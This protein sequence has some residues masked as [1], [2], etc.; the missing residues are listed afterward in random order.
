LVVTS[1]NGGGLFYGRIGSNGSGSVNAS[2]IF[3]PASTTAYLDPRLAWSSG[4]GQWGVAYSTNGI[5]GL[6]AYAGVMSSTSA[7]WQSVAVSGSRVDV[8]ARGQGDLLFLTSSLN[9]LNLVTQGSSGGTALTGN[10]AVSGSW[11]SYPPRVVAN[12]NATAMIW[13]TKSPHA[14]NWALVSPTLQVGTAEQLSTAAYY[15]DV[16]PIS[17][18]WGLAWIEGLG[19]R[20]MIKQTSGSTK[21]TSSV[22]PF[23]SV[24]SN[25]Q[26]ALGDTPNGT[27]VVATSPDSNAIHLYRFDGSCK[28]IDDTNLN[29]AASAPTTPRIAVDDSH[30][31]TYWTDGTPATGHY[32]FLSNL[33]CH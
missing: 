9:N 29:S 32:R 6:G 22:I 33:L 7:N 2:S 3:S 13:Q 8:T 27:V 5:G 24:A 12:G 20:F 25:Q 16:E 4:L 18:G 30:L 15:A 28:L 17:A 1:A 26:V 21:C 14:L 10:L 23:G 11:D 19:F 31:V